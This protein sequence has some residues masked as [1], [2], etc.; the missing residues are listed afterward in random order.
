MK[1]DIKDLKESQ[2]EIDVEIS[3][4]ELE[5]YFDKAI[6]KISQ[7]LNIKGFRPGKIPADITRKTAGD[8]AILEE[9]AQDAVRKTFID[10]VEEKKIEAVGNPDIKIT[11]IAIGNSL[12]YK[13]IVSVMPKISLGE[14][15]GLKIN[16][17]EIKIEEKEIK[18]VLEQLQKSKIKFT[19][20]E[21]AAEKESRVNL[22]FDA[23]LNEKLIE[24]GE[25][26][27]YP[28]VLGSGTFLPD[29]EE[30]VVGM[31]KGEEKQ[32]KVKMPKDYHKKELA[33]K[34]VEF[35]V[36]VNSVQKGEI[37]AIDNDFVKTL[38]HQGVNTLDELKKDI[39]KHL[40]EQKDKEGKEKNRISLMNQ[41]VEKSKMEIPQVLVVSELEKMFEEFKL[42][43]QGAGMK[44]EDY[45]RQINKTEED[46]KKEWANDAQMRVKM[47]LVLREIAKK[48]DI[49][50]DKEEI[51]KEVVALEQVY[52]EVKNNRG[53][54]I[55]F[56]EN[57][58]KNEKVFELLEKNAK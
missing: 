44:M 50:V 35:K 48:E 26:K 52:P 29:F 8:M 36:K 53:N 37:P 11:Q 32:F 14:Y 3:V 12:K 51:E 10:I 58:K 40:L 55:A 47:N 30:K 38:G 13:A 45:L 17:N 1:I 43:I 56:V 19:E 57:R 7:N 34:E 4:K 27:E 25:G 2:K 31:K 24:N 33:D 28:L 16:K 49:K 20:I 22:D 9:A 5:S 39:E 21:K 41:I 23:Y 6:T 54:A 18:K 46:I 15:K 42:N